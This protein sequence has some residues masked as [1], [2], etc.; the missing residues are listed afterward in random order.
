[1]LWRPEASTYRD[2]FHN[3][4]KAEKKASMKLTFFKS[5]TKED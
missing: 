1:M 2:Q 3:I 4:Q 5:G